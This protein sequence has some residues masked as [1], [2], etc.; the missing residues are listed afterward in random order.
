[1]FSL[2]GADLNDQLSL[3]YA[4]ILGISFLS[5]EGPV[6]GFNLGISN[7]IQFLTQSII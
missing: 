1:M 6:V 2:V 4:K 3:D 5:H 7:Q